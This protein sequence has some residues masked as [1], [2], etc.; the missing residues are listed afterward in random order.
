MSFAQNGTDVRLKTILAAVAGRVQKHVDS[1]DSVFRFERTGIEAW[2]K[3]ETVAAL[4][5]IGEQ[6]VSLNNKGPDMT[7]TGGLQIELKAATDFNPS[8]LRDGSL[9]DSAPCLFLGSGE[10]A[11]NIDRLKAMNQIRVI[12]LEY[13]R[14][15]HTWAVG[16]IVPA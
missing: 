2:F 14:G 10:N 11:S 8:Y 4:D 16:C 15:I 7:L 3:V 6:V 13:A 5:E 9:K 1:I 12:G